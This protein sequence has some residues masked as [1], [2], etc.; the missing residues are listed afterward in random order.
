MK[1]DSYPLPRIQEALESLE[2]INYLAHQVSNQDVQ[3]S[4][5]NLRAIAE[6]V[7]PQTYMEICAFLERL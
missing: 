1:K 3:P 7:L 5:V 4:D 6:C 2:E